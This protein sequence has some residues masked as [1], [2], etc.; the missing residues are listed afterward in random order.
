MSTIL[1]GQDFR[2]E[3]VTNDLG[4][5][6][7]VNG[8]EFMINGMN[9]DFV[10]IGTNYEYSLWNQSGD[11]IKSALDYEMALLRDMGVN[12]IRQYTGIPSK[13]VDYIYEN[14]GIYT[15]VNHSF[16]RY[17]LMLDGVWEANTD[18]SDPRVRE[19]LLRETAEMAEEYKNTP[20]VLMY[21][22]GNE[23]NY[24]LF[25][26]G[27]ETEDI[28]EKDRE[29]VKRARHMYRLFNEGAKTV[30]AIDKSHPVAVCNGDLL[31]LDIIGDECGNFDIFAVNIY[32]GVSFGDAFERTRNELGLPLMLTEFGADAYNTRD[33]TED[34]MSQARCLL[35]NWQEIYENARGLRTAGNSIGG[36]TFQ[37]SDGWWKTGQTENLD[38]HDTHASWS[39]GGYLSDY[40]HGKNN[41]NEEW[42]GICAKGQPDDRGLYQLYPRAAYFT[43]QKVH[44]LDPFSAGMTVEKIQQHFSGIQ[45]FEHYPQ[46]FE[47]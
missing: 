17:G 42:F 43:L 41:M 38:I 31:F 3:V 27:S 21:I 28:P 5:A 10:P 44:E 16:G 33:N 12:A 46:D 8:Q 47:K 25:W 39:N 40:E 7:Q 20:G 22:L 37:F 30:K 24:G 36:F 18:Y 26:E 1:A 19:L 4:S 32:R 23:N 34:Q 15:A 9:W 29:S 2:I 11:V 35:A 14:F 13:W 6:L 45:S